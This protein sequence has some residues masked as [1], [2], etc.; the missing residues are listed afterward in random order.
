[1]IY[2]LDDSLTEQRKKEIQYLQNTPY[3][4]VCTLIER[5]TKKINRD[6]LTSFSGDK[7]DL[8]CI[9]RSLKYFND[10]KAILSESDIIRNNMIDQVRKKNVAC[11]VFGR[12]MSRNREK[13]FIDKDAFY[14]NLKLFLDTMIAGDMALD[15]LYDGALYKIAER[16]RLLNEIINVINLEWSLDDEK[17]AENKNLLGLMQ[18]YFKEEEPL[19]IID[20]WKNKNLSKKEIRQFINDNL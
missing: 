5:P 3:S 7:D 13:L 15:I 1:M 2:I 19:E 14:R 18:Q 10:S 4:E 6:I 20:I 8:L 12:D 17:V 16:K 9:H 11:V